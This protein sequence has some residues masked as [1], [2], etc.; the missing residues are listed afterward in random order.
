M[1]SFDRDKR[2]LYLNPLQLL[3]DEA[4]LLLVVVVLLDVAAVLLV[5]AAVLLV[6]VVE[7]ELER[8][9]LLSTACRA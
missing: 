8:L 6:V 5:L 9:L 4:V 3:Q 7:V 1:A 2:E